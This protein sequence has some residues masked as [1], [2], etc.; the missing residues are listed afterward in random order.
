M[1]TKDKY[2]L[3]CCFLSYLCYYYGE[4]HCS[5]KH[6]HHHKMTPYL[7]LSSFAGGGKTTVAKLLIANYS[8]VVIPKITT[9]SRRKTEEIPEYIYV[10]QEEFVYRERKG[11]FLSVTRNGDFFHA[12]PCIEY[13]PVVPAGTELILSLFGSESRIV[14]RQVPHMKLCFI[15][16]RNKHLLYERLLHR[17]EIDGG[18][19]KEKWV[20][21]ERYFAT[22]I[23]DQY[24]FVVYNDTTPEECVEQIRKLIK[25]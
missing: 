9:R 5:P 1:V 10:S 12:I 20:K 8:C 2:G 6:S 3:L 4:F 13:W 22:A 16:C 14:Q 24:D 25:R 18:N 23:E 17:C 15:S 11:H 7:N 21:N 19:F